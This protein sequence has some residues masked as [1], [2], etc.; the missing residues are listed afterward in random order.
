MKNL[1]TRTAR[2]QFTTLCSCR[3]C[4]QF[5]YDFS[6]IVLHRLAHETIAKMNTDD[7]ARSAEAVIARHLECGKGSNNKFWAP[8]SPPR[9]CSSPLSPP[10]LLLS[11]PQLLGHSSLLLASC[12]PPPRPLLLSTFR[13]LILLTFRHLILSAFLPSSPPCLLKNSR[14]KRWVHSNHRR[15]TRSAGQPA[16]AQAHM[17]YLL[18]SPTYL[19]GERSWNSVDLGPTPA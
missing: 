2:T 5:P 10:R 15:W 8:L 19:L 12:A 14:S 18:I 3:S 6:R 13:H 9:V 17:T 11:A 16:R 4:A 7:P 1:S